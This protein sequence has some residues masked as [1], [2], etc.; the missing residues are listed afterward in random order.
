MEKRIGWEL[1]RKSVPAGIFY[2]NQA[3]PYKSNSYYKLVFDSGGYI[4]T[5]VFVDI[6]GK[7][8]ELKTDDSGLFYVN[9]LPNL[10]L[11]IIRF[12]I[13]GVIGWK[14]IQLYVTREAVLTGVFV[15]IMQE[16]GKVLNDWFA[17]LSG[18]GIDLGVLKT[19]VG[20]DEITNRFGYMELLESYL[21]WKDKLLSIKTLGAMDRF[22]GNGIPFYIRKIGNIV[23]NRNICGVRNI[24]EYDDTEAQEILNKNLLLDMMYG[25]YVTRQLD[26]FWNDY[27]IEYKGGGLGRIYFRVDSVDE[28]GNWLFKFYVKSNINVNY[29]IGLFIDNQWYWSD[30]KLSNNQWSYGIFSVE[31]KK[32]IVG[33]VEIGNLYLINNYLRI[34]NPKILR[35]GWIE[36][37]RKQNESSMLPAVLGGLNPMRALGIYDGEV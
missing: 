27:V 11:N 18:E 2:Q 3:I 22:N 26:T 21:L 28:Y 30:T 24:R 5:T 16:I 37:C 34:Y 25:G 36:S 12:R 31:G 13:S 6:N 1:A 9:F 14:E 4:N 20:F 29:K 8:L 10:G 33:A 15:K 7:F 32:V 19:I 17:N 23:I 35:V